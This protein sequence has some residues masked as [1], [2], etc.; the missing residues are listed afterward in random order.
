MA[1]KQKHESIWHILAALQKT[2]EGQEV[3]MTVILKLWETFVPKG[4]NLWAYPIK[5]VLRQINLD[6]KWDKCQKEIPHEIRNANLMQ[7]GNFIHVF[8]A[9]H[10]SGTSAHHQEH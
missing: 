2:V 7:Q 4:D 3:H 1:I 5:I 6:E 10:V 9:R 8:L